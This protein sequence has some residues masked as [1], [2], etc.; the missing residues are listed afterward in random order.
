[1]HV[2]MICDRLVMGGIATLICR[3]SSKLIEDRH[4]VTLL[5]KFA[6]DMELTIPDG[7]NL[8]VLPR[9][10]LL[11]VPVY[12][13]WY[14]K[15]HFTDVDAI[16]CFDRTSLCMATLISQHTASRSG[17]VCLAYS[18]WE[19]KP[20]NLINYHRGGNIF[21]FPCRLYDKFLPDTQKAFMSPQVRQSHQSAYERSFDGSIIFPV[22]IFHPKATSRKTLADIRKGHIVSVGRLCS[23]IKQYN[24]TV[25]DDVKNLIDEG[26]YVTWD[27]YGNGDLTEKIEGRILELG[28]QD[29]VF[30]HGVLDYNRF[31]DVV[32]EAHL[33][34]GMGTAALEA[35]AMGVPTIVA[36]AA[37]WES[38]TH[39][40]LHDQPFGI[41]GEILKDQPMHSIS[42][43]IKKVI[44]SDDAEYT[45]LS[46]ADQC[47]A[48]RYTFDVLMEQFYRFIRNSK[49]IEITSSHFYLHA[50]A[51]KL[52]F[53]DRFWPDTD[54][55]F[56][57]P[58]V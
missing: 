39:G 4:R 30:V 38:T 48:K 16:P 6:P 17:V 5:T 36:H 3:I 54:T 31:A 44:L 56:V 50:M 32:G 13:K 40:F 22:P 52:P 21:Q 11:M 46:E 57:N 1:M 23:S 42:N 14:T 33:F 18:P 15:K 41:L 7:V 29:S 45:G 27:I 37:T 35:A 2:L 51:C 19:M 8:V 26:F 12:A 34:I 49:P 28:I 43:F 9:L 25:L 53:G 58:T 20:T 47:A 10:F 55:D 24:F